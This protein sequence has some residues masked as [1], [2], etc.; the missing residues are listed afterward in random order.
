MRFEVVTM[1]TVRMR[2]LLLVRHCSLAESNGCSVSAGQLV[3]TARAYGQLALLCQ[4]HAVLQPTKHWHNYD[5]TQHSITLEVGGCFWNDTENRN[6]LLSSKSLRQTLNTATVYCIPSRSNNLQC[7]SPWTVHIKW[8]YRQ[9]SSSFWSR[10][11]LQRT[12]SLSIGTTPGRRNPKTRSAL[13]QSQTLSLFP[14]TVKTVHTW[15]SK[16]HQRH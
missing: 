13:A 1:V 2:V 6:N 10:W 14:T 11:C 5:T 4:S 12:E 3:K 9:G 7:V 8:N 16:Y 15:T